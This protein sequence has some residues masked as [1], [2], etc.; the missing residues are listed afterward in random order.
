MS[1]G[2]AFFYISST[3]VSNLWFGVKERTL[4]TVLGALSLPIVSI[5]GFILP[6]IF[7]KE[8]DAQNPQIGK[9]KLNRL[10]LVQ[11]LIVCFFAFFA[12]LF[13]RDKPP[14]PPSNSAER[15]ER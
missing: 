7:I 3:K 12:I 2:Q 1:I 13:A 15:K 5:L 4:S 8:Q 14:T 10:I 9:E 6:S 11:D